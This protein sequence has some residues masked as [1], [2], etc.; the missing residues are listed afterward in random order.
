LDLA[1]LDEE[2]KEGFRRLMNNGLRR[3]Q[4]D[5]AMEE[6]R[7]VQAEVNNVLI[8]M[9]ADPINFI[10]ERT[11]PELRRDLARH[12]LADAA[13]YE[14]VVPE[15]A[16]WDRSQEAREAAMA[17]LERD[18]ILAQRNA[19]GY[20]A[21]QQQ[22]RENARQI[23]DHVAS[24]VPEDASED[25]RDLFMDQAMDI[26]RRYAE[27]QD[28]WEIPV[29]QIEPILRQSRV[30]R[31]LEAQGAVRPT[32]HPTGPSSAGPARPAAPVTSLREAEE[33]AQRFRTTSANKRKAAAVAPPGAGP[34]PMQP[35]Q[36]PEDVDRSVRKKI[37]WYR[38]T[39][40]KR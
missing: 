16:R 38:K 11:T 40:L 34:A 32:P 29:E 35:P 28:V 24:M 21:R 13:T 7:G 37:A 36:A 30:L 5:M 25:L 18:R 19:E 20:L 8:A 12:L 2:S 23:R 1:D 22:S 17:T 6:L 9:S 39:M 10:M 4:L 33:T 3:D 31:L 14:S 27:Q 15:I 26:I